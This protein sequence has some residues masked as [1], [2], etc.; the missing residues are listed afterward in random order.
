MYGRPERCIASFLQRLPTIP[1][2]G[3]VKVILKLPWMDKRKCI[4]FC[5]YWDRTWRRQT[6]TEFK[7][8]VR[9]FWESSKWGIDGDENKSFPLIQTCPII[10]DRSLLIACGGR[11]I[12]R[13][14]SLK[15]NDP[16]YDN[17]LKKCIV[18]VSV[19]SGMGAKNFN[20]WV[21]IST[22]TGN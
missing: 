18:M 6:E 17:T 21:L 5:L 10:R 3:T 20:F 1:S 19:S 22:T 16:S 15:N 14:N 7:I 2:S 8:N 11:Q 4:L 12:G 9:L 13:N